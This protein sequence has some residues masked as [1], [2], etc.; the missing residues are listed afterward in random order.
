MLMTRCSVGTGRTAG[1]PEGARSRLRRSAVSQLQPEQSPRQ[2]LPMDRWSLEPSFHQAW[3]R[4]GLCREGRPTVFS[5]EG[6][7]TGAVLG[8]VGQRSGRCWEFP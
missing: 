1:S 4:P 8:R 3:G 7:M 2:R 6:E 5:E